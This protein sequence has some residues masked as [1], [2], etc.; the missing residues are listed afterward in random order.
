MAASAEHE[1]QVNDL[2]R[3]LDPEHDPKRGKRKSESD[4]GEIQEPGLHPVTG[5]YYIRLLGHPIE[6]DFH[7]RSPCDL[8]VNVCAFAF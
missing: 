4:I 6:A 5:R 8:K 2:V 3:L 1:F 7:E